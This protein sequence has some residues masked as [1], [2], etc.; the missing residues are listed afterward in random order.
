MN[1]E[2]FIKSYIENCGLSHEDIQ[3]HHFDAFPCDCGYKDCS[4]W[5][6]KV[7]EI[8]DPHERGFM[9]NI[10]EVYRSLT[11]LHTENAD[12]RQRISKLESHQVR[13]K[14]NDGF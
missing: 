3:R 7:T 14:K 11:I 8:N 10:R 1:K 6:I 13:W 5:Q 4:H 2:E 9:R 12:L